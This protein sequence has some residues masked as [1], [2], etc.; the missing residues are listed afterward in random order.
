MSLTNKY[1]DG[2]YEYDGA[3][4]ISMI[5]LLVFSL[6]KTEFHS[7]DFKSIFARENLSYLTYKH[8]EKKFIYISFNAS[9]IIRTYPF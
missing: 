4:T 8:G 6:I 7:F 3:F 5:I 9:S 2:L 1:I